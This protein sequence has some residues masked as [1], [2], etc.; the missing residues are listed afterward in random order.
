MADQDLRL[1]RSVDDVPTGSGGGETGPGDGTP[2]APD[3][4]DA[5]PRAPSGGSSDAGSPGEEQPPPSGGTDV[6]PLGDPKDGPPTF[7]DDGGVEG[8]V[9]AGGGSSSS[10]GGLF[11]NIGDAVSDAYDDVEDSVNDAADDA[12]D[13]AATGF[14]KVADGSASLADDIEKEVA[15]EWRDA[16]RDEGPFR[17]H[18]GGWF[19]DPEG[20]IAA[21]FEAADRAYDAVEDDIAKAYEDSGAKDAYDTAEEPVAD[22]YDAWKTLDDAPGEAY[23]R[24]NYAVWGNQT[25][26]DVYDNVEKSVADAYGDT[27]DAVADAGYGT[28]AAA[29]DALDGLGLG[30]GIG[31]GTEVD[32][33]GRESA[34][35]GPADPL[36]HVDDMPW[37][38]TQ[39]AVEEAGEEG[40]Q[41]AVAQV[42]G[43][44]DPTGPVDIPEPEPLDLD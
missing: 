27:E 36:A 15:E 4:E 3:E 23:D 33:S 12:G 10:G 13:A 32:D 43:L 5:P 7:E 38:A 2:D 14:G 29:D 26:E 40:A 30:G 22:A 34:R 20:T 39:E 44:L 16:Q 8:P 19:W 18:Q 35:S 24:A 17:E 41:E 11:G 21:P 28:G 6:D 37:N 9:G 1:D 42:D 25:G 31:D